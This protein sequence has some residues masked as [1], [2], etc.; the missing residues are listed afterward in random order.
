M[1]KCGGSE[2]YVKRIAT[3]LRWKFLSVLKEMVTN[4]KLSRPL[5]K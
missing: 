5:I 1:M 2:L 3:T 4:G